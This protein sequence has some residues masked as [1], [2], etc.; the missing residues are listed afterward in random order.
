M[1]LNPC[2]KEYLHPYKGN[3][4]VR[5]KHRYILIALAPYYAFI[6]LIFVLAHHSSEHND[7]DQNMK[8]IVSNN[9]APTEGIQLGR[10]AERSW[11]ELQVGASQPR[12]FCTPFRRNIACGP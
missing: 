3:V 11:I 6:P 12:T 4:V 5:T 9:R 7:A 10:L 1:L 8:E 2:Y